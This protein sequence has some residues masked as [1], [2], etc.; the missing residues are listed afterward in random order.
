[1]YLSENKKKKK[2]IRLI[3]FL[4]VIVALL[5]A[6]FFM[7]KPYLDDKNGK[8]QTDKSITFEVDETNKSDV[9]YCLYK[10][11]VIKSVN[12]FKNYMDKTYGTNFEYQ[13]GFYN[14]NSNMSYNRLGS[15]FQ[16]PDSVVTKVCIP[17]GKTAYDIAQ[18]MEDNGLCTAK[19]FLSALGDNYN[20]SF[21][22]SID[23]TDKR[24][25]KL[26]GYLFPATYEI[27]Q[28]TSAHDIIDMMLS[29]MSLRVTDD[30]ISQCQNKNIS[31][32]EMLT[33]ASII[34]KEC[35]GYP[36]E[37]SKVSSVF[38]N[39]L[40]NPSA[41]GTPHLGSDPTVKYADMLEE[42]G[43]AKNIWKAYS[44]YSC[45]GLPTGPICSPSEDAI[46]ASLNPTESD[47]YYFFTD[48]NETFYYFAT[49]KE[50]QSAWEKLGS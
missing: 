11:G 9:P 37:M 29:A 15:K 44:T 16:K 33:M 45:T 46:K 26:E 2:K 19:Q 40:N 49:Y 31:V 12:L 28:G 13:I 23:N 6:A 1:M 5:A 35:S 43:Y 14:I 38:W 18:I 41:Q 47:Y 34:E 21:L 4:V 27:K 30:I 10:K 42:Q 36:D 50:F 24:P 7:Y 8:N 3:I 32:D 48:K 25:Y 17:E 39:R 20:Y 22:S